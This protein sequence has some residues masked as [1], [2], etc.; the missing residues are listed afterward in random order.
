MCWREA[1]LGLRWALAVDRVSCRPLVRTAL[2]AMQTGGGQ[3]N[4]G[5]RSQERSLELFGPGAS[6]Q[7]TCSLFKPNCVCRS[8]DCHIPG[9]GVVN[10]DQVWSQRA[11]QTAVGLVG[12]SVHP[13]YRN[14]N[15]FNRTLP[16][17]PSS[18]CSREVLPC[19]LPL[20][21]PAQETSLEV[22]SL[23]KTC[24]NIIQ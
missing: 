21:F 14:R 20:T 19:Y 4:R 22:T 12:F 24:Q 13:L 17:S 9:G 15:R 16:E 18:F 1:D 2:K 11:P 5:H 8:S 7:G 10:W 23:E 6:L 3:E